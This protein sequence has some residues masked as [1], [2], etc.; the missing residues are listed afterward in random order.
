MSNENLIRHLRKISKSRKCF[1]VT[2]HSSG[3][4]QNSKRKRE[5][6]IYVLLFQLQEQRYL[7]KLE[8]CRSPISEALKITVVT[9][10]YREASCLKKEVLLLILLP[11]TKKVSQFCLFVQIHSRQLSD[12]VVGALDEPWAKPLVSSF[13]LTGPC[14]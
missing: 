8:L 2:V 7:S 4:S 6:K 12:L 13:H 10:K 11:K 5:T 3:C 9:K 1:F 14:R